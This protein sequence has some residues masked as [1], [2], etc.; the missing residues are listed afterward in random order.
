MLKRG[1]LLTIVGR[2]KQPTNTYERMSKGLSI[3]WDELDEQGR[4]E[5][6]SWYVENAVG[7]TTLDYVTFVDTVNA[8]Q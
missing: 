1:E 5:A 4:Y 3:V 2:R 7:P 6:W 8:I